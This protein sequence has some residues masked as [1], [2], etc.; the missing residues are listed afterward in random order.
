MIAGRAIHR[1]M[2]VTVEELTRFPASEY[3]NEFWA[4]QAAVRSAKI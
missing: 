2:W 3:T 4:Q 1:R